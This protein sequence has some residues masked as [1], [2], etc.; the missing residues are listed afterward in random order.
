MVFYFHCHRYEFD[1]RLLHG[2]LV[3]KLYFQLSHNT[4]RCRRICCLGLSL[5]NLAPR[6]RYAS[7]TLVD[8]FL[9]VPPKDLSK[10][11][12]F[13]Q[14]VRCATLLIATRSAAKSKFPP[15]WNQTCFGVWNG[16]DFIASTNRSSTKRGRF[17][18]TKRLIEWKRFSLPCH[19]NHNVDCSR[20]LFVLVTERS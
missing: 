17:C 14:L 15:S 10:D 5:S 11:L 12:V 2:T 13:F 19:C 8:P 4:L 18:S 3:R 16:H 20:K 1:C 9:D 7:Y 6:H